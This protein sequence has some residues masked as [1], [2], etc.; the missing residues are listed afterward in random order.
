LAGGGIIL[1]E[2][3]SAL[4]VAEARLE[5]DDLLLGYLLARQSEPAG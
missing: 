1:S 5:S 4:G 2:A 3:L